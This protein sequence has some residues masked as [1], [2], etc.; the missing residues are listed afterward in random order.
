MK[1]ALAA[2]AVQIVHSSRRGSRDIEH[3]GSAH[4]DAGLEVLKAAARQRLAAGQGELD[5]AWAPDGRLAVTSSRMSHLHDALSRLEAKARALAGLKDYI[6]NLAG[7]PDGT[8]RMSKDDLQPPPICHH[9]RDSIDVHLAI[10]FAAL[11][12]SR[13]IGQAAGWSIRSSSAPP[14]A[15]TPSRS[16]PTLAATGPGGPRRRAVWPW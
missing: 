1:T 9:K 13:W 12:V 16:R 11:A 10:L 4:D 5:L 15:T 8:F 14:A 2:T 3:I 7:C 6:T